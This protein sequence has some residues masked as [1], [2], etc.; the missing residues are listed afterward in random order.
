LVSF[1]YTLLWHEIFVVRWSN[2]FLNQ[3]Q[4][5]MTRIRLKQQRRLGFEALEA[6]LALSTG[7]G[8]SATFHHTEIA[9]VSQTQ[10]SLKASFTGRAQLTASTIA[11]N[12][13][14]GTIGP[15]HFTGT[16]NGTKAG[17][18]FLGGT[19]FLH[20]SAGTITYSLTPG[21]VVKVGKSSKQQYNFVAV[22]GTG[23]YASFV[24]ATGNLT[25][26]TVPAKKSG[27]AS[28]QGTLHI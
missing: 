12:N 3:E 19:V 25:K 10:T 15:D 24:G 22:E 8:M 13:L 18:H 6:R 7:M 16:F 4:P 2:N 23:K 28:I 9:H 17:T 11:I 26:L 5:I 14:K 27:P 20:N 21:S 1:S